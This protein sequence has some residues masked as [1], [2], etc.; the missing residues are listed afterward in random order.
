MDMN[1]AFVLR[2]EDRK[3]AWHVISAE[4]EVLGRLATRVANILRGKDKPSFTNHTDGGDYVVITNCEKIV[5]TGNKW[6]D[7][8]YKA[9]SGYKG[10]LK[11]KTAD[12]VL[13]DKPEHII[14]HAVKGMLPNN[15][16]SRQ[17]IKKLKVY[18]GDNHPHEAQVS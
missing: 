12:K 13:A 15:R 8:E 5:M 6:A 10:G 4:G 14:M 16:L 1:R 3:P 9:F 7:K 11:I 18:A 17:I 2:N